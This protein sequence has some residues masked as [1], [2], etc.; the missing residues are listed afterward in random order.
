MAVTIETDLAIRELY[1]RAIQLFDKADQAWVDCRTDAP[2]F[3]FPA[4]PASGRPE[5][6][7]NSREMLSGMVVQANAMMEGKGLHHLTNLTFDDVGD[8]TVRVKGYLLFVKSGSGP[9][10][11]SV[12]IQNSRFDDLVI[13]VDGAW[14]FKRRSVG[15]LWTA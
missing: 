13:Q 11:P 8:G 2:E 9:T 5:M 7:L 3:Y 1:A 4:D 10:D 6:T 14:K 12:I 15:A